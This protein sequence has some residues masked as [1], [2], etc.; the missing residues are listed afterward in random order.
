MTRA[1]AVNGIGFGSRAVASNGY[2]WVE[3]VLS[4][5][6]QAVTELLF[7]SLES[8]TVLDAG[9]TIINLVK[10][11]GMTTLVNNLIAKRPPVELSSDISQKTTI[12]TRTAMSSGEIIKA[13]TQAVI[14]LTS[15]LEGEEE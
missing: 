14:R 1:L 11:A 9:E 8:Q 10:E 15:Q 5:L 3:E 6:P 4:N 7:S 12:R 13:T 2:W